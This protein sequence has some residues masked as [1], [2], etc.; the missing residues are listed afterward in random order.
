ME[1]NEQ[2]H[3]EF[4]KVITLNKLNE[5][6][7]RADE[8]YKTLQNDINRKLNKG[9]VKVK[10][11]PKKSECGIFINFYNQNK[12]KEGHISLHFKRPDKIKNT[13]WGNSNINIGRFHVKNNRYINNK[14]TLRINKINNN[15]QLSITKYT[16]NIRSEL[17]PFV[18]TTLEIL[19]S[20]FYSESDNYL[21]VYKISKLTHPCL[22]II[23]KCMKHTKSQLRHTRKANHS[24]S[25][26]KVDINGDSTIQSSKG[27]QEIS[28]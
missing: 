28:K 16:S 13:N 6:L 5:L 7:H 27:L 10:I 8:K 11:T 3:D 14:Y 2:T 26:I 20:Y 9:Y 19:N 23:E 12:I 18:D 17:K 24:Q 21:G 1:Q 25:Q 15:I 22:T 4:Y